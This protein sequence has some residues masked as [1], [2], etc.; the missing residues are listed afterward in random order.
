[1]IK[2]SFAGGGYPIRDIF[3]DAEGY[4]K[5]VLEAKYREKYPDYYTDNFYEKTLEHYLAVK[6]LEL[7]KGEVFIDI[8]SERSPLP[9]ICRAMFQVE[10]QW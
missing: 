8:A 6:Y 9:D 7:K 3:V 10:A 1:M 4:G 5:F 2:E